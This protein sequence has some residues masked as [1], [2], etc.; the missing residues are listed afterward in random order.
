MKKVAIIGTGKMG[1]S[2]LA[3]ANNTPGIEVV[4][5]CDTS[6]RTS[7]IINRYCQVKRYKDYKLMLREIKLD[8]VIISTPNSTHYSIVKYF[9]GNGKN[10]FVEKPFTTDYKQSIELTEISKKQEV[11]GQVGYVNRFNLVFRYLR[12][13]IDKQVVG[14]ITKYTNQM[15]GGVILKENTSGWR[16]SYSRGGGCLLDYGPHCFDLSIYL[17]GEQVRVVSSKL[18]KIFSTNVHD[19]VIAE[20]T[21]ND[22]IKGINRINWSVKG[23]RKANNLIEIEGTKG[24]IF[25]NKQEI[26]VDL[27]EAN[28]QLNL[29]KG[30]NQTYI[31]DL[32]TNV[33]YYLRGE[34]FSMQMMEFS[35]LLNNKIE[36]SISNF[37][38]ARLT[39]KCIN[40]IIQQNNIEI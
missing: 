14:E 5:I 16:N 8:A 11:K 25:A 32:N 22:K 20:F 18:K 17:F 33:N 23:E 38:S 30:K 27:K 2:H 9:I 39:D 19:E 36:E 1:L 35:N 7:K 21:H 6:Q 31:T 15:L 24:N 29:S 13:L 4:A 10:I 3:I 12:S 40:D 26:I 34:D 37:E 28:Y